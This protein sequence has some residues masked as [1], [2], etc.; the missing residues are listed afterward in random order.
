MPITNSEFQKVYKTLNPAQRQAVDQIDGPVMVI[1][2]PGTGK[3]QVL[4]A[5]IANILLKTD[6]NPSSVLALT[7]TESAAK[8][9]RERLV[10]MIGKTGY[11][12]QI[13][14]FHSFCTDVI[15]SHPEFFPIDRDSQPLTELERYDIMQGLIDKLDLTALKPLNTPY[16]YIK[17][18][19]KSI[20]DL[21]REGLS[22][23]EFQKIVETETTLFEQEQESLKKGELARRQKAI[24]KNTELAVIYKAYQ[25]QLRELLRFDF[26]DMIALT[27]EAFETQPDLLTEYQ[28]KLLYFLID[29]YQDTNS[30]QNKVVDLLASFWEQEANIFV[31]G[32]PN[33]AIYRFQGASLENV[34][35]FTERYPKAEVIHLTTGYR[36]PQ[37][38]YNAVADLIAQNPQTQKLKNW[39]GKPL[40]SVKKKGS[41]INLFVAP[42]QTLEYIYLAS[43]IESLIK[44][45]VKPENIAILYRNNAE[46]AEIAE[47]L[48]KWGIR[49]EVD[50][51][52]NVL[53]AEHIRQLLCLFKVIDSVRRGEDDGPLF[54]VLQYE[55]LQLEP[56]LVMKAARAASKAKLSLYEL[57]RRGYEGFSEFHAT[58][59]VTALDFLALTE[60]VDK[61]A[62]WAA[63]D[64]Q[65][66]FTAWFELVIN[67]SGFLPWV[68]QQ[69]NKIELLT[70][71]NSLFREIKGLVSS[72]RDFQL[73]Q[74]LQVIQTMDDHHLPILLEDMNITKDAVH[75]STVHKAKG[76]EWEYV[77]ITRCIDKKWGN[78]RSRAMIPMPEGILKHTNTA[79]ID[80]NADDR[81]LLYVAMSRAR[82]ELTI[83][84]P[85]TIVTENRSKEVMGSMFL[86]EIKTHLHLDDSKVATDVVKNAETHLARLL[87]VTE[88]VDRPDEEREF[89][90]SLVKDFKL[91]ATAL[92][93]Y[94]HSPETFVT[95][96]L[97]KVP[98][99]KSPILSFGSAVH[100]A[101]EQWFKSWQDTDKQ[102]SVE[103][104]L[105]AFEAS[106]AKEPLT[107]RDFDE[108][109]KYGQ[110]VLQNYYQHL[111]TLSSPPLFTERSFGYGWSR[112]ILDDIPL[113]G[114]IDRVDWLDKAK[115]TVR[116]IDYK[117]GRPRTLGE[118][119]GA[120]ASS[121]LSPREKALPESIRGGYKRQLVFYKLLCELDPS[122]VPTVEQAVFE[123]IEPD[124]QSGKLIQRPVTVTKQEVEALKKVI[125]EVMAEIRA[126]KFLEAVP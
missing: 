120:T 51:G 84:Y 36:S 47:T 64:A 12:V 3:T 56:V 1:A 116:V 62:H 34:L 59:E 89:Y 9:M 104:L 109:L 2:G 98:M 6:T 8:N 79:E 54:E 13:H 21:K 49:Y 18:I 123:F 72:H 30:A 126:L 67:D 108:R 52:N 83:S 29:E 42:S 92:N 73:T 26:E 125:R 81:R 23:T 114:R 113:T 77:F 101:L 7:F 70:T 111:Q 28:E 37:P 58:A 94:L 41:P 102:A 105:T 68:L 112:T 27:V 95:E 25:D 100:A 33:Q 48:D 17:D 91:S 19:L 82:R 61:L 118:I 46:A 60:F 53:D 115:K 55:W 110:T 50:G 40:S 122:F 96:C 78:G 119:E 32:D 16:F 121:D 31:V 106:L 86:E 22:V 85:E 57:L 107:Q 15:N 88:V 76:Q 117:T 75:L 99:A 43:K 35:S 39:D 69:P 11:Y 5:R 71:V 124:K 38:I 24:Q 4:A 90:A 93:I 74:F 65:L 103:T 63:R 44:K 87:E 20:S 66:S 10:S 97:L 45:D 80:Q 14:T